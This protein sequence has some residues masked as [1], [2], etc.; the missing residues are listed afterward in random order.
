MQS[1]TNNS[2]QVDYLKTHT[3]KKKNREK[4]PETI[5]AYHD[6]SKSKQRLDM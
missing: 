3:V 6:N 5:L 1:S 2:K 4:K